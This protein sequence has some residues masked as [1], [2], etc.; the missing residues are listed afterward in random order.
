MS[1]LE[2]SGIV[3][4]KEQDFILKGISFSQ[5]KFDKIAIA[6]ETGSGKTSLLKIIA[7]LVTPDEGYV[8]FRNERV[9]RVPEEKLI[10]GHRGI[11][12]L[13]QQFELP[14]YL[15]V[16]QV[17]QYANEIK[18]KEAKSLFDLC[19]ISH[20]LKRRTDELSGG[21]R[22]RIAM[23]RLLIGSPSLLLLDEP[24]SNLDL[25]H[26]STLKQ[27]VHDLGEQHGISFIL[28]SHDPL[29]TL[30]WADEVM[31]MKDGEIIQKD[32]SQEIYRHPVNEY[33]AGLLG[34]Y[35]LIDLEK[36]KLLI[37]L[38][39]VKKESGKVFIRPEDL[40]IVQS[41]K[42]AIQGK[43]SRV[44]FLGSYFDLE[45]LIPGALITVRTQDHKIKS[46][47]LVFISPK[48]GEIWQFYN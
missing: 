4:K 34:A 19:Q 32:R 24:F 27:I 31:I 41:G 17:L 25:I 18:E 15:R 43:V 30:S 39:N 38:W 9:K 8:L 33:A 7:G 29:D 12:Y 14:H 13:S 10:P 48:P 23:A 37:E 35:N 1:Y 46:G 42:N 6:G 3:K 20:L 26:K 22:Q 36:N 47:E 44:V 16:E 2:V 40:Q 11:A 28:V 21:E 45:V 5:K